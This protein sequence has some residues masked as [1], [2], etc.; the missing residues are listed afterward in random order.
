VRA[1]RQLALR[2][3]PDRNPTAAPEHF[4]Q[5]KQGACGLCMTPYRRSTLQPPANAPFAAAYEVL[6]DPE[7]RRLYDHYGPSLR[8]QLG[9]SFA[10]LAPLLLALSTGF[11]GASAQTLGWLGRASPFSAAVA[12]ELGVVGI[13]GLYYCYPMGGGKE[14]AGAPPL[15]LPR[16]RPSNAP[17]REIV[18]VAD[19]A[20]VSCFGLALGNAGGWVSA[21]VLLLL[22]S[23]LF[24]R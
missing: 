19:Y 24:R 13:A 23:L 15:L 16:R 7:K 21:S 22:R 11:V 9:E 6:S 14:E 17:R 12:L 18:G 4:Q 2:Y 8:P 10:Q 5:V 20:A 3:H 1:Y